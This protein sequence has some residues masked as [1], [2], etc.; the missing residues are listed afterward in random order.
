MTTDRFL[1]LLAVLHDESPQPVHMKDFMAGWNAALTVTAK[2]VRLEDALFSGLWSVALA[3][4][5]PNPTQNS[6]GETGFSGG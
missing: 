4:S 2:Q 3:P 6:K 1:A 5:R